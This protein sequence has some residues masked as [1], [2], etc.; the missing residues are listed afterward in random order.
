M[1]SITVNMYSRNQIFVIVLVAYIKGD[2][3]VRRK[4]CVGAQLCSVCSTKPLA[5]KS[6]KT[7][8]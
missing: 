1:E 3:A 5:T 7:Q 2:P 8:H 6:N 4:E